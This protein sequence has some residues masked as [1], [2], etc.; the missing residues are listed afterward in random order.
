MEVTSIKNKL[1]LAI[2]IIFSLS[3]ILVFSNH[4][5][6]IEDNKVIL[7]SSSTKIDLHQTLYMLVDKKNILT[8]NDI[9]SPP[10][11]N[12][13]HPL[14]LIQQKGGF[15]PTAK[16]LRFEVENEASFDDE[17]LFEIDFRL[18][19]EI[20]LYEKTS[21]GIDKIIHT[22][23][24][25]PFPTREIDHR[26]FVFNLPIEPGETKTFYVH[27]HTDGDVHPPLR[28]WNSTDFLKK[29][30]LEFIL[31]GIFYGITSVMILYNL[32]LYFAVRMKSYLFYVLTISSTVI[33]Y[34]QNNGLGYQ[35]FW[36]NSPYWNA[37]NP[38]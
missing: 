24:N 21:S 36:P 16:W 33:V 27:L 30:Q 19:P 31:L 8:L 17:W 2:I 32:F 38:P 12:E 26:N 25:Y 35:F 11:E 6:A 29:T 5:K 23:T 14:N 1:L 13:F 15:F 37:M 20:T 28:I 22:G 4:T 34:L 10:Y 9:T 3:I 18:I 7:K